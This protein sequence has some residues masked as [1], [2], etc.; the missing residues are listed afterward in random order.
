MLAIFVLGGRVKIGDGVQGPLT[1]QPSPSHQALTPFFF[2][3][4]VCLASTSQAQARPRTRAQP[5]EATVVVVVVLVVV[6]A[7]DPNLKRKPSPVC[8]G[9]LKLQPLLSC[10]LEATSLA[11]TDYKRAYVCR[12]APHLLSPNLS[13][14]CIFLQIFPLSPPNLP[15]E[16][17]VCPLQITN[18]LTC[19][20]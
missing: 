3:G 18:A 14:I 5:S 8:H 9:A 19:A 13:F 20:G 10:G 2:C 12:V 17:P 1:R 11:T 6:V 16:P 4:A 15:F 7:P